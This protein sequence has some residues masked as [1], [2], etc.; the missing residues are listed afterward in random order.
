MAA[1]DDRSCLACI[2]EGFRLTER[3]VAADA[4]A[5]R[6]AA[7]SATSLQHFAC[8]RRGAHYVCHRGIPSRYGL[9]PHYEGQ[10]IDG[11]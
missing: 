3:F 10:L 4:A 11:P 7:L 5:R 9:M 2:D 8:Q 1:I 6:I